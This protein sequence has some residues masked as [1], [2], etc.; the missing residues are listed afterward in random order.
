MKKD[1]GGSAYPLTSLT[2]RT[3][4]PQ[5]PVLQPPVHTQPEV[6]RPVHAEEARQ[7]GQ[8]PCP[9]SIH[10]MPGSYCAVGLRNREPARA[11][12]CRCQRV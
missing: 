5:I 1:I 10:R 7:P 6:I 12:P 8:K 11:V 3:V 9:Q 2:R 4:S